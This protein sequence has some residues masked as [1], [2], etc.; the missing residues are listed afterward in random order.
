VMRGPTRTCRARGRRGCASGRRRRA[1]PRRPARER[2]DRRRDPSRG[3]ALGP[4]RR[5]ESPSAVSGSED[6]RRR[7][8]GEDRHLPDHAHGSSSARCSIATRGP[9]PRC[10]TRSSRPSAPATSGST[11]RGRCR[12]CG[13]PR[14]WTSPRRLLGPDPWPSG[15]AD[16]RRALDTLI[17]YAA[18]QGLIRRRPPREELFA[19]I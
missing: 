13:S 9:R 18:A 16:D 11:I 6:R 2:R 3:A 12:S 10:C 7:L 4:V 14:R 15:V 5:G 19:P 1:P 8:R 17:G